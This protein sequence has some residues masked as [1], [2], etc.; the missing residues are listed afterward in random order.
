VND[1]TTLR[2]LLA[3]VAVGPH[4]RP[5]IKIRGVKFAAIR[6]LPKPH[7]A[8]R[9]RL[10]THQ[11]TLLTFNRLPRLIP[12]SGGHAQSSCLQLAGIDRQSRHPTRKTGDDIGTA[13]NAGQ[14]QIGF[15]GAIH[16]LKPLMGQRRPRR[17]HGLQRVQ[18]VTLCGDDTGFLQ[19]TE[20]FR[21][22]PK[23]RDAL[24]VDC[25]D[26]AAPVTGEGGAV[27]KNQRGA[28]SEAADQPVPH[29]PA[30]GREIKKAIVAADVG[31]QGML[32]GMLD[33]RATNAMHDA[34]RYAGGAG[35]V[36]DKEWVIERSWLKTQSRQI[37]AQAR[38]P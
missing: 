10:G 2:R 3:V 23:H 33:Q 5:A 18:L 21:A 7:R 34:L 16:P 20:I 13:R 15:E 19:G 36:K 11:F 30:A 38:L 17:Q 12:D 37:A 14:V 25:I 27:V 35:G 22:N 28:S 9:K 6:I 32:L 24:L 26:Q 4:P 31:V 29:H 1:K 8:G